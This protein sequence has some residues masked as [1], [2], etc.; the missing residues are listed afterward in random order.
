MNK[1]A[2]MLLGGT[3]T[4]WHKPTFK[5]YPKNQGQCHTH[6]NIFVIKETSRQETAPHRTKDSYKMIKLQKT[7]EISTC[8][9]TGM[10]KVKTYLQKLKMTWFPNNIGYDNVSNRELIFYS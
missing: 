5:N 1:C 8:S 7:K 3:N 2:E 9:N 4:E 6:I 10:K